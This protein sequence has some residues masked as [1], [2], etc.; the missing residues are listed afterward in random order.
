MSIDKLEVRTTL[1]TLLTLPLQDNSS[2]FIIRDID[3]LDPVNATLVS[4]TF[5]NMD[6]AQFQASRRDIRNITLKLKLYPDY[7]HTTIRE[8]RTR[9]YSFFNTESEVN[10]RFY[11]TDGLEVEI[12]GRVESFEAPLFVQEPVADISIVCFDP[13][14]R[15]LEE[16]EVDGFTVSTTTEFTIDYQGSVPTGIRFVL[17]LDRDLTEFTIYH[18]PP[19]NLLRTFD[20]AANLDDNDV[21]TI[22]SVV[23][24]KYI[25]LLRSSTLTSLLYG[26][27]PQSKWIELMPG[28]NKFRIYAIGAGIPFTIAYKPK[29]GGL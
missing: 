29:Y 25:T 9:L 19:D 24:S 20:F 8:L 14:F 23:G 10:L 27:S 2:G 7:V 21:L 6:G 18:R 28:E 13:D 26:R 1:G 3:G 4:S 5:A 11:M 22:N 17:E 12:V 15:E 16:I